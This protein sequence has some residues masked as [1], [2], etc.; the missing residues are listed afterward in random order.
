ML[1][2]AA[3]LNPDKI[4]VAAEDG[5][6]SYRQLVNGARALARAPVAERGVAPGDTVA[7]ALPPDGRAR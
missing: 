3:R 1:T 2:A 7:L 5:E 4:A 6:L